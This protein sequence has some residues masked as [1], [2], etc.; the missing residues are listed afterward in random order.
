M[1]DG[2]TVGFPVGGLDGNEDGWLVG[3][4]VGCVDGIDDGIGDRRA[5]VGRNEGVMVKLTFDEFV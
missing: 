3:Y 1:V 2:P 4:E 5:R